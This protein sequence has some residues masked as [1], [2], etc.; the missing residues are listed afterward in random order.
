MVSKVLACRFILKMRSGGD[1]LA[2]LVPGKDLGST[3]RFR[4]LLDHYDD[5]VARGSNRL[6]LV[7]SCYSEI[8]SLMGEGDAPDPDYFL[9]CYGRMAVNSFHV[10]DENQVG[11]Q[12]LSCKFLSLQ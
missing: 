11:S 5:I 2:D 8:V 9:E 1:R 12:L 10:M 3:R 4:D 6:E 7:N